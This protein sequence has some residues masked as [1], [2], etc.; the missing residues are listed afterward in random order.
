MLGL[1]GRVRARV[2]ANRVLGFRCLAQ[3]V[4]SFAQHRSAAADLPERLGRLLEPV[5]SAVRKGTVAATPPQL[6]AVRELCVE[7]MSYAPLYFTQLLVLLLH[8]DLWECVLEGVRATIDVM[9]RSAA[10]LSQASLAEVVR[11]RFI[12]QMPRVPPTNARVSCTAC[13]A[14]HGSARRSSRRRRCPAAVGWVRPLCSPATGG[15]IPQGV[16]PTH[17]SELR[18][19]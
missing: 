6:R 8:A 3:C 7:C 14:P 9:V 19:T 2:Q 1:C 17:M 10:R 4:R 18:H 15:S 13:A 16:P 11:P 12:E 5:V